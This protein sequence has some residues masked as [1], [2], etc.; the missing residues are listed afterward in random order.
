MS[1]QLVGSMRDLSSIVFPSKNI[2][3]LSRSEKLIFFAGF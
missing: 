1:E 3:L 2:F